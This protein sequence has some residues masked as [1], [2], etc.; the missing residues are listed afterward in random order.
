MR[1]CILCEDTNIAEARERSATVLPKT[2]LVKKVLEFKTK[3]NP[4]VITDHLK[5]PL[6]ATGELPVTH[7]FCFVNVNDAT[8]QKML[9]SQKY[10]IIEEAVP[11][12]FL[13]KHNLKKIQS[14]GP[15]V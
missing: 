2:E 11:S 8:Y 15:R 12:E 3:A 4:E 5:I 13:E 1:L 7:W 10:T 9:T 14:F 6:S